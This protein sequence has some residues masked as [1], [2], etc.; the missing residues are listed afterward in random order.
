M[1]TD[2][3]PIKT[4]QVYDVSKQTLNFRAG[5]GPVEIQAESIQQAITLYMESHIPQRLYYNVVNK[6][7][8][9]EPHKSS[10]SIYYDIESLSETFDVTA[11]DEYMLI[12]NEKKNKR[13][14]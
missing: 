1:K 3:S 11:T 7:F 8:H 4:Y 5:S 14:R 2:S 12:V 9:G 6:R 13:K 10:I